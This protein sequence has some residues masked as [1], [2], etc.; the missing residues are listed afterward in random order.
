MR[1]QISSGQIMIDVKT[2]LN[3]WPAIDSA[4]HQIQ[5]TNRMSLTLNKK[6]IDNAVSLIGA[7]K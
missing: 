6:G 3:Q 2:I 4:N 1:G 5:S 7:S